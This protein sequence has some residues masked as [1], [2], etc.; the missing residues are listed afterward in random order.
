MWLASHSITSLFKEFCSSKQSIL[1]GAG[2][3][4]E[5]AIITFA[6]S[7][8]HWLLEQAAISCLADDISHCS[9]SRCGTSSSSVACS[10]SDDSLDVSL[11][12]SSEP[13]EELDSDPPLSLSKKIG[14]AFRAY[15]P[16][17]HKHIHRHFRRLNHRVRNFR[18]W[19]ALFAALMGLS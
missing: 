9:G 8:R 2:M 11:S 17:H 1:I 6:V 16:L 12:E 10:F 14:R 15:H 7:V 13:P 3:V 18:Y 4:F 5:G 19:W